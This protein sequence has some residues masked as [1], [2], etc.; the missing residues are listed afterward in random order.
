MQ[1]WSDVYTANL[2]LYGSEQIPSAVPYL[3]EGRVEP[4]A[5]KHQT[6]IVSCSFTAK[7]VEGT[8]TYFNLY[9]E[10]VLGKCATNNGISLKEFGCTF[11][12]LT[13]EDA[14]VWSHVWDTNITVLPGNVVKWT[15][16]GTRWY[17]WPEGNAKVKVTFRAVPTKCNPETR[18]ETIETK[19]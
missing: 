10:V 1:E 9:A 4:I 7:L 19:R 12:P 3:G 14:W 13:G 15:G 2:Y 18:E 6:A 17:Y 5:E 8:T 11:T 16:F